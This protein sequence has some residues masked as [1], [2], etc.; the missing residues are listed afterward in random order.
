MNSQDFYN[1]IEVSGFVEW[2]SIEL[3]DLTFSLSIGKSAKAPYGVNAKVTGINE[4]I[5]KYQWKASWLDDSTGNAIT[6]CGWDTTAK[7]LN[8]LS[9][10][11][12]LSLMSNDAETAF[13]ACANV[14]AWGG[15]R[16]PQTGARKF[17]ANKLNN[18]QLIDYLKATQT[19]FKLESADLANLKS[20]ELVNSMLT[21]VY[22]LQS[23]D[24]LPIYDTRVAVAIAGLIEIYRLKTNQSW[25]EVPHLLAFPVPPED[26]KSQRRRVKYLNP[27]ALAPKP[28]MLSYLG[29]NTPMQWASA[30]I[31]LGWIITEVLKRNPKLLSNQ[32]H[33][34]QHAFEAALF[35][36]GY[37]VRSLSANLT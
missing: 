29:K 31:R 22:A 25:T 13:K 28:E 15:E 33:S 24:G 23:E 6:S 17:L 32:A 34:R 18:G 10:K 19:T 16:N 14:F 1:N 4:V 26:A 7:S 21:K 12:K 2:L 9:E 3:E 11:L 30:K 27:N 20:V 8:L 5:K 36:I 37:D 35:M